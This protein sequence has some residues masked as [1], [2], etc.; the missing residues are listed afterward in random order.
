MST[1][2]STICGT[3]MK[4]IGTTGTGSTFHVP[5]RRP[6]QSTGHQPPGG[7]SYGTR[8]CSTS[9]APPPSLA[10]LRPCGA[11][12][13]DASARAMATVIRAY[14]K[15]ARRRRSRRQGVA[16]AAMSTRLFDI[17]KSSLKGH[18][19][20]GNAR[21]ETCVVVVLESALCVCISTTACACKTVNTNSDHIDAEPG[22]VGP[23]HPKFP[24][25]P[26]ACPEDHVPHHPDANAE[27][28]HLGPSTLNL[29]Q[30]LGRD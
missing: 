8:P 4:S 7:A 16:P 28:W 26:Q 2:C 17:V 5:P 19:E 14:R 11:V 3:T 13:C 18:A 30:T 23:R 6:S 24:T 20:K 29:F 22:D 12:W 9:R 1:N 10:V 15:Y 27:S 25:Q 21:V